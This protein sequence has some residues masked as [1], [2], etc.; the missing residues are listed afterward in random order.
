[1]VLTNIG[2]SALV[3]DFQRTYPAAHTFK[4]IAFE[5]IAAFW[6]SYEAH[7]EVELQKVA[8]WKETGVI[9]FTDAGTLAGGMAVDGKWS[10]R[11]RNGTQDVQ[12]G[13]PTTDVIAFVKVW[14]GP[15]RRAPTVPVFQTTILASRPPR[16]SPPNCPAISHNPPPPPWQPHTPKSS[17]GT[18]WMSPGCTPQPDPQLQLFC[19]FTLPL[20][21]I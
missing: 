3:Q 9:S 16:S 11:P 4:I 2:T 12:D 19:C 21:M 5:P 18:T 13:L 20:G 1:M 10:G 6:P 8:A 15:L 17:R 7:P 14:L